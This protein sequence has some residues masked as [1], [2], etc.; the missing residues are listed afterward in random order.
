MQYWPWKGG[1][2]A[3]PTRGQVVRAR[4]CLLLP[5]SQKRL[6]CSKS[7]I[8]LKLGDLFA[9]ILG[10]EVE[11]RNTFLLYATVTGKVWKE[12]SHLYAII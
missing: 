6:V 12:E 4:S 8:L 11:R 1:I 10:K 7:S 5:C 3:R 9:G 2:S